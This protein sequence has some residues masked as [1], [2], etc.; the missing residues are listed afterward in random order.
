[1]GAERSPGGIFQPVVSGR[2]FQPEENRISGPIT[3]GGYWRDN[4]FTRSVADARAAVA[5]APN[6]PLTRGDLSW[7][8]ANAGL[9][10]EAAAWART[11]IEGSV[12]P[13]LWLH[14]NLGWANYVAGRYRE[15]L[16]ASRGIEYVFAMRVAALVRLGETE[17]ARAAV[18]DYVRGRG[19]DTIAKEARYPQ[20]EPDRTQFLDACAW[21][22]S[23]S[24][25]SGRAPQTSLPSPARLGMTPELLV[26][27]ERVRLGGDELVRYLAV[28]EGPA[29]QIELGRRRAR[30]EL[31]LVEVDPENR[32]VV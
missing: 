1:M 18:A 15:A 6:D 21:L 9:G 22:D 4:D 5:L 10:D 11:A 16:E 26:R 32:R 31:E 8:L 14:G 24:R 19:W 30:L 12:N 25:R 23:P 20:I 27:E 13:P 7:V 29:A 17:A 28:E 3:L 2:V